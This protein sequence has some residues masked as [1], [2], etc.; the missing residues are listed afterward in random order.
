MLECWNAGM[1]LVLGWVWNCAHCYCCREPTKQPS[2]VAYTKLSNTLEEKTTTE[3]E[4]TA[5]IIWE[6]C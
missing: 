3:N 4:Y 1:D 6:S 5:W 2:S